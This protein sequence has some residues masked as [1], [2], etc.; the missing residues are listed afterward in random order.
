MGNGQLPGD[1]NVATR[2]RTST[3]EPNPSGTER[4]WVSAASAAA[5]SL[6]N[7]LGTQ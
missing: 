2:Q 4:H 7:F 3:T 6:W 5:T 1:F